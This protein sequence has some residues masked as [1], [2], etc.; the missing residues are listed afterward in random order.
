MVW[1]RIDDGWGHHRKVA[2]AGPEAAGFWVALCCY[3]NAHGTDGIIPDEDLGII[4]AGVGRRTARRL[5][6]RLVEAGMIEEMIPESARNGKETAK[7]PP[8]LSG[9]FPVSLELNWKIHD[10]L[11]YNRSAAEVERK[12]G[13]E[14]EKKRRQRAMSPGDSPGLSPDTRP[15]PTR[16]LFNAPSER[17]PNS[18]PER[19]D[20]LA[21]EGV[22]VSV[23]IRRLEDL[24]GGT[25]ARS[26][27][28]GIGL[29]R[30]N[31]RVADSVW[32]R[33]LQRLEKIGPDCGI[34]AMRTF[35]E[36]HADGDKGEAYL[37]AIARGLAK[38]VG[39]QVSLVGTARA[40]IGDFSTV[41]A[42]GRDQLAAQVAEDRKRRETG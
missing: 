26:A 25:L 17:S 3:S 12:R 24:F 2:R 19:S 40:G 1:S 42:G 14:R 15:D 37:V 22:S 13:L 7:E 10:F 39:T 29:S 23:E 11:D 16:P 21:D 4:F 33:T 38:R 27:R 9:K 34:A 6:R 8:K 20:D 5:V 31:G 35:V 41:S 18:P 30:K 36:R 32:V 28:E